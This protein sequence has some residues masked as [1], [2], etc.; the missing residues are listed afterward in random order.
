MDVA[1]PAVLLRLETLSR[2][3]LKR[4]SVCA[5]ISLGKE[6]KTTTQNVQ[7]E[8]AI[9]RI[10]AYTN[11]LYP[12]TLVFQSGTHTNRAPQS[13]LRIWLCF[14]VCW[15]FR[16]YSL[17]HVSSFLYLGE[18]KWVYMNA[19]TFRQRLFVQPHQMKFVFHLNKQLCCWHRHFIQSNFMHSIA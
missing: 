7:Q 5:L 14:V 1:S 9:P 4:T 10:S 3:F 19:D 13:A 16:A 6:K 17:Y 18:M 11:Y 8:T 12:H 15:W 2:L